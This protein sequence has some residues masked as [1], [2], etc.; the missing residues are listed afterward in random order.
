MKKLG[1]IAVGLVLVLGSVGAGPIVSGESRGEEHHGGAKVPPPGRVALARYPA[2]SPDGY[3]IAFS[4]QGDIWTVDARGGEALRLT[5]HAAYDYQPRWSPDG[6]QIAFNSYRYGNMDV[7]VMDRAG[8]KPRRITFYSGSDRLCGWIPGTDE[9]VFTSRRDYAQVSRL[10]EI[11]RVSAGGGTP[12]RADD[13]LGFQAAYSPDGRKLA[14]VRGWVP[15]WRKGYRGS[16]NEDIWIH[17]LEKDTYVQLTRAESSERHPMWS[18]DGSELFFVSDSSGTFNLWRISLSDT[19]WKQLTFHRGDGVRFPAI[20][21]DG[22]IIA[23]ELGTEIWVYDIDTAVPRKLRIRAP[24]DYQANRIET[25]KLTDGAT[26]MVVSPD[27]KEVAFVARGDVFVSRIMKKGKKV[28]RARRLTRSPARE[29]DIRWSPDGKSI[30]FVSDRNGNEDIFIVRSAEKEVQDLFRSHKFET[31]LVTGSPRPEHK[32]KFSPNGERIAYVEGKGDLVVC[33]LD[34]TDKKTVLEGWS[35]PDFN[36]SP[37]G[38]W[39]AYSRY[40]DDFNSDVFIIPAEGGSPVNVSQ[41]PDYDEEPIWSADGRKLAFVSRQDHDNMDI[42]F[43]FLR[44]ADFEKSEEE[45]QEEEIAEKG[46]EEEKTPPEVRIDFERIHERLVQVTS[47]PGDERGISLS[48][49]GKTF[50]FSGNHQG[51]RDLY[52]VSWQGEDLKRLTGGGEVPGQ[53]SWSSDGKKVYFLAKGGVIKQVDA[54]G[55]NERRIG[56]EAHLTI[57]HEAERKQIFDEAWRVLD[58]NF[59]DPNFH[60]VVWAAEK[61]KYWAWARKAVAKEDFYDVIRMMLGELNSSHLGL[62]GPRP[63]DVVETGLLGVSFVPARPGEGLEIERVVPRSPADRE[64]SRLEAGEVI[65]SVNGT[66][67]TPEANIYE[68][69]GDTVDREIPIGVRGKDGKERTVVIRPFG[70]RAM[71]DALYDEWVG[72]R[73]N[74]VEQLSKGVLGYIHIRA[75]GWASLERFERELFSVAH[76]KKGLIIDVRYNG[77]GWTTDYLLAMLTVKRHAYTVPRDGGK[78]YPQ[79]RLPFYAWT[80]PS[81]TLCNQFSFSN[82]EIFSHA[83]KTLGL[84]PLVGVQTYGGVISTDSEVLM[85]GSRIRVPMRGWYVLPTGENMEHGG[86][87][88][89]YVVYDGP[90][91]KRSGRDRQLERAV[92]LLLGEVGGVGE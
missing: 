78:G 20:C 76:G 28:L 55:E 38:E 82:A 2:P 89:D 16:A 18:P 73:R 14:F 6:T 52:T 8:G 86:A 32:P 10:P 1:R 40:D 92:G 67:L 75:M 9:L 65:L 26:E 12:L 27:E 3:E 69:L 29:K 71:R 81:V 5:A 19:T 22:G 45:W 62:Y 79:G 53:I 83:Y 74:M 68:L 70:V 30:L 57:D 72:E 60:G 35:E 46:G 37:D 4:Y 56:V 80:K 84:G 24:V 87:R 48:P 90:G 25:V 36:W 33:A 7:F 85:D 88:P 11:Y 64:E 41:H 43:V 61:E 77:G 15:W 21:A 49:D 39:I 91:D 54:G 47:L 44:K 42:W 59:Y 34:G 31:T 66:R 50:A 63:K 58:Q 13:A 23:Y 17:D 51:K